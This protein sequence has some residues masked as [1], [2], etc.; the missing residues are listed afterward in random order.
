MHDLALIML[1]AAVSYAT[2]ILGL[3]AT[4]RVGTNPALANWLDRLGNLVLVIIL[5]RILIDAPV[6]MLAGVGIA[7]IAMLLTSRFLLS[8]WIGV[9]VTAAV[10]MLA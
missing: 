6:E 1:M 8:M 4:S 7:A 2:R 3:V 5:A 9:A 10:R